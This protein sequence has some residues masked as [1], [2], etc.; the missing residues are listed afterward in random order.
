MEK[1]IEPTMKQRDA[2]NITANPA[3]TPAEILFEQSKIGA[4]KPDVWKKRPHKDTG[5]RRASEP[6]EW[7]T[8]GKS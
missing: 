8:A 3:V 1:I 7:K 6:F 2:C 5:T 4:K